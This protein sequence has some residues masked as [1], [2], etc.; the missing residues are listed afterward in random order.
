LL[1]GRAALYSD[2]QRTLS[3]VAVLTRGP[4]ARPEVAARLET[5][6]AP[7]RALVTA[8][9]AQ[10]ARRRQQLRALR[11]AATTPTGAIRPSAPDRLPPVPP[12]PAGPLGPRLP[13]PPW[14]PERGSMLA[15]GPPGPRIAGCAAARP[16]PGEAGPAEMETEIHLVDLAPWWTALDPAPPGP[17]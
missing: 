5:V 13:A 10:L 6:S 17:P 7:A 3:A 9:Q 8:R 12:C 2:V 11:Q 4:L 16:P 1:L 14:P 15:P